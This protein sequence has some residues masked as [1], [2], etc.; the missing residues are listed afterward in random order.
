MKNT[1]IK[2]AVLLIAV[3]AFL[4]LSSCSS[5]PTFGEQIKGE[6]EGVA[7]IGKSWEK[8]DAMIKK[9]N[10]LIDSGTSMQ[11]KGKKN[12]K[13]GED[14]I[15]AGQKMKSESEAAYKVRATPAVTVGG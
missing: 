10:K 4:I 1:S 9:G 13:K 8:G 14:L 7:N 2:E 5:T 6:G 3:P 15:K 12:V 11:K